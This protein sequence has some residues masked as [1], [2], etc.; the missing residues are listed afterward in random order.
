MTSASCER[1]RYHSRTSA[2]GLQHL[3]GGHPIRRPYLIVRTPT[4]WPPL[5]ANWRHR[6]SPRLYT[7]QPC[8]HHPYHERADDSPRRSYGIASPRS[9]DR[10]H[11]ACNQRA[12]AIQVCREL[13]SHLGPHALNLPCCAA[14]L[15]GNHA[16]SLQGPTKIGQT[17]V[18]EGFPRR[19]PRAGEQRGTRVGKTKLGKGST[20]SHR[21]RSYRKSAQMKNCDRTHLNPY[22]RRRDVC[23][24]RISIVT[25]PVPAPRRGNGWQLLGGPT[26]S[27]RAPSTMQV[28]MKRHDSEVP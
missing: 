22:P 14:P 20:L 10:G 15:G 19:Q 8:E 27:V 23:Q 3:L 2:D 6:L 21:G 9:F 26:T 4:R 12:P 18:G 11:E 24:Q 17:R 28:P 25:V 7:T 13:L 16:V 5:R 1:T